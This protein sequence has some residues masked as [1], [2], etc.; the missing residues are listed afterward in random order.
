MDSRWRNLIVILL[1]LA[2]IAGGYIFLF[3]NGKNPAAAGGETKSIEAKIE[4]VLAKNGTGMKD[5]SGKLP[6]EI[7]G[8]EVTTKIKPASFPSIKSGLASLTADA[9]SAQEKDLLSIYQSAVLLS[10]TKYDLLR[11]AQQ[12]SSEING[13]TQS[14]ACA[15]QDRVNSLNLKYTV[16]FISLNSLSMQELDYSQKYSSPKPLGALNADEERK[17]MD[18]LSF[19]S[20]LYNSSCTGVV[21]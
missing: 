6:V 7:A 9:K 2:L 10:E 1:A 12:L 15:Y 14:E 4:S 13:K 16:F 5:F 17:T 21:A 3:G 20:E 11:K 18:S 19:L 8:D